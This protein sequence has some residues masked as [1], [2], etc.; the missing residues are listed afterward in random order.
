M[1]FIPL[2]ERGSINLDDSTLDKRVGSDKFVV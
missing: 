2:A 1:G